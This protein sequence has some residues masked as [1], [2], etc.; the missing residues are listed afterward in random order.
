VFLLVLQPLKQENQD[1]MRNDQ[2]GRRARRRGSG[3]RRVDGS[4][5]RIWM[6][7]IVMNNYSWWASLFHIIAICRT[8]L[9]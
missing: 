7:P 9:P 5:Y 8:Y 4:K 6:C 3:V 1:W 2:V